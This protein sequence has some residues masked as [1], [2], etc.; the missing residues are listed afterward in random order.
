[1]TGNGSTD[2]ATSAPRRL[3]VR[4][5]ARELREKQR[6]K[7]LRNRLLL[8][9]G[10]AAAVIAV[11]A[12]VIVV[13][14]SSIKPET[15]GPKN[16]ASDGVVIG[17]ELEARTTPALA[18]GASPVPATSD[19]SV[20]HIS[21]YVDY[22]CPW[23]GA[24]ESANGAQLSGWL[25]SGA[26]VLEIHPIAVLTSKSH[27]SEYSLRAANAAACVANYSPDAF[28]AFNQAMFAQQ[29]EE[30]TTGLSDD[31]LIALARDAGASTAVEDCV[32]DVRFST[33]V[34]TATQRAVNGPLPGTEVDRVEATPT[35]LVNGKK[36]TGSLEDPDEFKAFVIGT[37][38]ETLATSTPSETETPTPAPTS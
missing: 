8:Q 35:I 13:V 3:Q 29:P 10:V 38:S 20:A 12:V 5:K 14:V 1:M 25:S 27:G 15:D 16:M 6:K 21:V 19:P 34:Q 23:C 11:I 18:A 2:D 7:D 22:L 37:A 17:K 31:E 36:Y 4:E 24:F 33:W 30:G 28:F 9:G 32:D 26:A